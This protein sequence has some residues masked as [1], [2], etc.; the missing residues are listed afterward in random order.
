MVRKKR[1]RISSVSVYFLI[2]SDTYRVHFY[3][4]TPYGIKR[5]DYDVGRHRLDT[6]LLAIRRG[7]EKKERLKSH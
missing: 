3:R 1:N 7:E 5:T 2:G 4:Q 6:L